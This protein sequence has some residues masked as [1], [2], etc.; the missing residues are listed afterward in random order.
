V[1]AA[2][3]DNSPQLSPKALILETVRSKQPATVKQLAQAIM[4]QNVIDELDF[5]ATIKAMVKERTLVL[6]EPSYDIE[7]IL[8]YLLTPNLSAWFWS[9][10]AVTG[11]AVCMV[12]L[13]PSWTPLSLL[14]LVVGSILVLYLPGYSSL[15]LLYHD[16]SD[17]D[18]LER[19]A[20][21]LGVSIV[22]VPVIGLI[23]N[24]TPWGIRLGSIA[25]SLGAY[26]I[27]IAIAAAARR[28][29]ALRKKQ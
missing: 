16:I 25:A 13:I 18:E 8:D 19:L 1:V 11:L 12:T 24:F 21:R 15:Q 28:Y 26:V 10:L 20:L 5:V 6:G 17:S 29:F 27:L 14:R 4:A 9:T 22:V 3:A 7:S 23:L 2:S